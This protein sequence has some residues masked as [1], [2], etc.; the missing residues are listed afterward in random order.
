MS[1]AGKS[2]EYYLLMFIIEKYEQVLITANQ[3]ESKDLTRPKNQIL[4]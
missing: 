4:N 3:M 1:T 2:L